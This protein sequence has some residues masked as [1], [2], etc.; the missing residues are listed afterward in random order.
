[1]KIG[2]TPFIAENIAPSN[3]SKLAIFKDETKVCEV[4]IS[5][6]KPAN[7]G[8]KLYSVGLV[9]DVH[10]YSSAVSWNPSEKFD[11]ALTY[12]ESKGCVLVCN[13]GD[14]TQTGFFNEGDKETLVTAQFASYKAVC[15]KHNIP[16]YELCGNHESYVNPITNNLTELTDYTGAEMYYSVSQGDDVYLFLSQPRGTTPMSDDALQWLFETLEENRNK[17]CFVFVHPHISNDSGNALGVYTT[18]KFFDV[19]GIKTTAFM[20]LLSHFKNTLLFHGHSHMMFECQAV[21]KSANYTQKNGFKSVHIPSL[22]RP[23]AIIDGVRTYQDTKSYGYIMDVYQDHIMLKGFDFV[24]NKAVPLA[25]Y[26][27][28]TTLV[29]IEPNTFT[30]DTG[31]ITT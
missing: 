7:L 28:D 21:D 14:M 12:F 29:N 11:N 31:T 24:E 9:S 20:N 23:C 6:M 25:T 8:N 18:N 10:C 26:C 17:R 16:I 2:I 15:D 13:S 27:I 22:T 1:M 3:A 4:D 19:W 30:D 5:R